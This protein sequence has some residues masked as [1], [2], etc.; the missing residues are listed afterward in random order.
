MVNEC[1]WNWNPLGI[2][3]VLDGARTQCKPLQLLIA[4]RIAIHQNVSDVPWQKQEQR[5]LGERERGAKR[6]R[7]SESHLSQPYSA[8]VWHDASLWW[9]GN[10]PTACIIMCN[11]RRCAYVPHSSACQLQLVLSAACSIFVCAIFSGCTS[12]SW[13]ERQTYIWLRCC[14][15]GF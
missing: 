12:Q 15:I 8:A 14:E 13:C 1:H 11:T 7:E 2:L 9:T 6:A 5:K 10:Y 4:W 3:T